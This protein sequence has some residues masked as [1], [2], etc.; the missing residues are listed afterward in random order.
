MQGFDIS[1]YCLL[2]PDDE[3]AQRDVIEYRRMMK[4][5]ELGTGKHV[6]P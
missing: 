5:L 1:S 3:M 4:F 6:D 2:I